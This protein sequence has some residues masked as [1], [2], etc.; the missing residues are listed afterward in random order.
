MGQA[1]S[2]AYSGDSPRPTSLV[3]SNYGGRF[4]VLSPRKPL[5]LPEGPCL[6]IAY[7]SR[8]I[9]RLCPGLPL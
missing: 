8:G 5:S 1:G 3:T 4:M 7:S 9:S 6:P 2:Q